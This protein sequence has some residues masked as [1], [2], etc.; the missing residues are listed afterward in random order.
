[1][2]A[3]H[4]IYKVESNCKDPRREA[5]FNEWYSN[6]HVPDILKEKDF[7]GA[8]RYEAERP[9]PGQPQFIALFD[10]DTDNIDRT[11][12]THE[13][14]EA[15]LKAAGRVSDLLVIVSRGAYKWLS[16]HEKVS[17]GREPHTADHAARPTA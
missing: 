10:L 2:A 13:E 11:L 9:Q 4:W 1:M 14:T 12:K 7:I 5:E 15:A 16:S 3:A 6:T 8:R 17:G